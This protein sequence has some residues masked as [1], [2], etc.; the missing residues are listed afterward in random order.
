MLPSLTRRRLAN[1]KEENKHV[2]GARSRRFGVRLNPGL[3]R[4]KPRGGGVQQGADAI[5][6]V[7]PPNARGLVHIGAARRP[8]PW[9]ARFGAVEL[10]RSI[11]PSRWPAL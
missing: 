2:G 5:R 8:S 3:G 6:A 7:L 11:S 9:A 4:R 1:N 10:Q